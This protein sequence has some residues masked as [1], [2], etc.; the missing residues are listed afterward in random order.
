MWRRNKSEQPDNLPAKPEEAGMSAKALSHILESSTRL[1][2]PAIRAYVAKLRKSNP[3]ATPAEIITKLEKHYLAAV[4]ASGAA[5]GSAAAFPGIGTLTALSAVAGETVLFLEAT[6]AFSL[7][8]AEVH[9]IP[10]QERERRR[11]L[12]LGVLVGEEGKGAVKD[13]LGAGRTSGAWLAE[14]ELL[15]LP[16]VSQLN[17]KFMQYF[18][19][20]YTVK[21]A[22]M[23]FGK[24]LPVGIG[25]AIGGGGNRLMGKK[26]VENSRRAFGPAPDRWPVR[27]H[28][29]P[30][31]DDNLTAIEE[32]Q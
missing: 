23:A 11:N 26:I 25:A 2:A 5:V 3:D 10:L 19:K 24:L 13:L 32:A 4:M 22:A 6:A 15:P 16:V 12:V 31:V 18:V 8:V 21:R 17:N 7:A 1:Q 14:A 29:L 20:K 28:L 27:L 9:G 30:G